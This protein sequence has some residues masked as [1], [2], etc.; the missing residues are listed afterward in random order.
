MEVF[1]DESG[2]HKQTDHSS[3]ALVYVTCGD[4]EEVAWRINEIEQRLGIKAFHWAE[5]NW[6]MRVRFLEAV[7]SLPFSV[8]VALVRNP[9]DVP[10]WFEFSVTHLIVERNIRKVVIDGKKPK[11]EERRLKKVLRDKGVSVSKVRGVRDESE[12]CLRLADALAGLLRSYWDNPTGP[13][14]K[15]LYA[16]Y[17]NKITARFMGGQT[18]E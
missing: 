4:A 14:A 10:Q 6:K 12:P 13:H 16:L 8:K 11:W 2:I 3:I 15:R 5:Y 9:V 1:I 18:A 17:Q 7:H